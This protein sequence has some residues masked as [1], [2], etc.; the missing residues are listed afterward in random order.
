MPGLPGS[1]PIA[2]ARVCNPF[3][4]IER[5]KR[6]SDAGNLPLVGVEIG[7]NRFSRQERTAATGALCELLK[8]AFG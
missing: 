2:H 5:G 1:D 8:A 6:F 4:T 7:G 3:A